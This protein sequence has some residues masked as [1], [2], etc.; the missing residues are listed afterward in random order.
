MAISIISPSHPA[1]EWYI[2]GANA[3]PA[4]YSSPLWPLLYILFKMRIV[5]LLMTLLPV[6]YIDW[7]GHTVPG[8]GSAWK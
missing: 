4:Q 8:I 3:V 2:C 5:K 1:S 7:H 6:H